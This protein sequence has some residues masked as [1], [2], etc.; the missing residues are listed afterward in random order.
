MHESHTKNTDMLNELNSLIDQNSKLLKENDELR[1]K[2]KS[3]SNPD[4][5]EEFKIY[6]ES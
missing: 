6:T 3:F 1:A 5:R 2:A 4:N